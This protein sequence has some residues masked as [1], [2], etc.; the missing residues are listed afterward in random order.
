MPK[1]KRT[2]HYVASTHWDREWYES[3]Q[4]FRFRLVNLLDEVLD[5]LRRNP[6]FRYFQ[7]DGQT[8]LVEDYLEIRPDKEPDLRE[9]AENGRLRI[10]PWY[11]LPDEFLVSGES[12]IR[13]LQMGLKVASH[14]GQPSRAGFACDLFGHISQLPQILRGFGIDNVL[15]MRGTT[16]TAHGA[17]FRWQAA[18]GSEIIAYRFNP[19]GG[20]CH[21]AFRVRNALEPD[22]PFD[23]ETAVKALS[24]LVDTESQRCPTPSFL[25]FDGGDHLEIEPQTTELLERTNKQLVDAEIIHSHLDGFIEDLREQRESITNIVKGEL[26]EPGPNGDDAWL[27]PGVLSSRIHL[28]QANAR[29]ENE[30]CLW[31]EPFST[32]AAQLGLPYPSSYLEVAWRHL[33]RN[34][35]HDSI[36]GCSIDQVH[37]DMEYRFDQAYGIASHVTRDALDYIANRVSVPQLGEDDIALILFNPTSEPIDGPIDLTLRFPVSIDAI[38]EEWF[39]FEPKVGFRLYDTDGDELP[40]Q[41]VGQRLNRRGYRRPLRKFPTPERRHEIDITAAV[42]MPAYGYTTV[43]CRPIKEPTRHLGSMAVDDHTIENDRLRVTVNRNGTLGLTD[44]KTDHTYTNLLTLEDRA[45]IGDG[46]FHGTTVN[47]QIYSSI[48]SSAD[49]ALTADGIAKATLTIRIPFRVPTSFQFDRMTRSDVTQPLCVTHHVTLRQGSD[50]VEVHTIVENTIRDHRLRVLFPTG[51][52]AQTYLADQAFDV[53]ERSIALRHDNADSKELEVETKPQ[54]T[55][56]AVFDGSRGL[57]IVSTGLPES[58]VRDLPDR[59]IALTLLRS[60]I[61]AVFSN[62]NEGGQVQGP[63]EFR[64]QIVPLEGPPDVARLTRLGQQLA[65]GVR[66]VTLEKRDIPNDDA[67]PSTR[68]LPLTDSFLQLNPQEAVITSIQR[69]RV[70]D[71]ATIRMFNP[72]QRHVDVELAWKH[73]GTRAKVVDF[74]SRIGDPLEQSSTGT[75]LA[76]KPKQILTAQW[77]E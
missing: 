20:Y 53:V 3:F 22:T 11:V 61:K 43:I 30:L 34:H 66:T 40:Y 19:S 52:R 57:A 9:F 60:F 27:I 4:D 15:L 28:K 23:L 33:L 50:V 39:G 49:V 14:F 76:L 62:A 72:Y 26:R 77:M 25:V 69:C 37:K 12:I 2:G 55:W 64:Y 59:P 54:Q 7:T 46:W 35:P 41:Y 8:V 17:L 29:C 10:G 65:A 36:C 71:V 5:T 56:S 47:E 70:R 6:E 68:D 73:Q 45:D 38:Y 44:K 13:N 21:Y 51:V 58:A 24:E 74:E 31:A 16:E 18:D 63:H 75:K 32:F 48:A 42:K 1:P 67:S